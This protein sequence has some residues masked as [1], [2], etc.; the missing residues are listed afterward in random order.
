MEHMSSSHA[1]GNGT[2]CAVNQSHRNRLAGC[3]HP[4]RMVGTVVKRPS[5]LMRHSRLP[6]TWAYAH[7][8]FCH[9]RVPHTELSQVGREGEAVLPLALWHTLLTNAQP[10]KIE[11]INGEHDWRF[12]GFAGC[13]IGEYQGKG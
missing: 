5:S 6:I 13:S 9:G 10:N 2:R 12:M 3:A 8:L 11:A 7:R 4:C 1:D